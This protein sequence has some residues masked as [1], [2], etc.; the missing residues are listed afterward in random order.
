MP[1]TR[2]S[3]S[4]FRTALTYAI[5]LTIAVRNAESYAFSSDF[6]DCAAHIGFWSATS[7]IKQGRGPR[8]IT[9]LVF[10]RGVLEKMTEIRVELVPV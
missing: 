7:T 9:R 2:C 8:L 3:S 5:R 1:S 4:T 10:S 6:V